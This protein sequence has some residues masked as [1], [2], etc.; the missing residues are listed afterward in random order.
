L[1]VAQQQPQFDPVADVGDCLLVD[2]R[3]LHMG[4]ANRSD[5]VRPIL[6]NI[7]Q[8]PWFRDSK[9][10]AKQEP[11][12]ISDDEYAKIP[13]QHRRLFSWLRRGFWGNL[14]RLLMRRKP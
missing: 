14:Q 10:Y 5:N 2:Y 4:M 12:L 8:R 7:Y 9:N 11:I 13:A 6:Y 1:K 3:L